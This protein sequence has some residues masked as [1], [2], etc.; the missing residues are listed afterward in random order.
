[1]KYLSAFLVLS[2]VLLTGCKQESKGDA[3]IK[4]AELTTFEDSLVNLTSEHSIILDLEINNDEITEII[5]TVNYYEN[6]EFVR[7]VS[8]IN[9]GISEEEENDDKLTVGFIHQ[10]RNDIEENW[11]TAF[12][13]ESGQSSGTVLNR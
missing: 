2:L 13:T 10:A 5:G 9:T 11:I 3:I 12:M 7:K 4:N 6:G 1:L 8:E